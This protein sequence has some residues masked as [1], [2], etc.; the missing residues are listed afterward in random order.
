[1]NYARALVIPL[2][3]VASLAPAQDVKSVTLTG[4]VVDQMC[5]KGIAKKENVMEKAGGHTKSCALEDGCAE[6]GYGIFSEGKWYVFDEAGSSTAKGLIESSKREKGLFF[7]A[8]GTLDGKTL[9]L[10]S[11]KESSPKRKES[12]PAKKD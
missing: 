6:S 4:Y 3:L 5:A 10:A 7:E 11:L 9:T 12:K 8:T 2:I 1:M